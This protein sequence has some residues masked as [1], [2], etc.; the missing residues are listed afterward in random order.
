MLQIIRQI[1]K[2]PKDNTHVSFLFANQV[3]NAS[4]TLQVKYWTSET[5]TAGCRLDIGASESEGMSQNHRLF[6]HC[7]QFYYL[8]CSLA[9]T[10][11]VM[12]GI[13]LCVCPP[14][15]LYHVSIAHRNSL[16]GEGNDSDHVLFKSFTYLWANDLFMLSCS[17]MSTPR[18]ICVLLPVCC[19]HLEKS[20]N[21]MRTGKWPPCN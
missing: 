9:S 2:D 13:T 18:P 20:G 12:L 6:C 7:S 5:T 17:L 14:S 8:R 3:R 4:Y 15:R 19:K 1:F 11:I 10:G 21:L 16:G